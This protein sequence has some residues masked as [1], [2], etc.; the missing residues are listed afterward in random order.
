MN[1]EKIGVKDAAAWH[2]KYTGLIRG[3]TPMKHR[4]NATTTGFNPENFPSRREYFVMM[5]SKR[6]KPPKLCARKKW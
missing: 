4:V 5:Q 2:Q 1:N 6:G 3:C